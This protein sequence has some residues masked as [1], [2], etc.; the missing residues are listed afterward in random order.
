MYKHERKK[1]V[2]R[3]IPAGL[4][5]GMFVG[6]VANL[7]ASWRETLS[8]EV[9]LA[10]FAGWT[11]AGIVIAAIYAYLP[12][13]QEAWLL[14]QR[15][16]AKRREQLLKAISHYRP[17]HVGQHVHGVIR[18]MLERARVIEARVSA[19][20][21]D[22]LIIVSPGMSDEEAIA[23]WESRSKER[24]EK[25]QHSFAARK[26]E[27]EAATAHQRRQAEFDNAM[28]NAPKMER[29]EQAWQR[30][31][32]KTKSGYGSAVL[33]FAENWARLMQ[34]HIEEGQALDA[35]A[36]ETFHLADIEG[37]TGLMYG[38]AVSILASC[39]K[40]GEV[41]RRWHN[42]K[43]QI[44]TEGEEVNRSGGVLNPALLRIRFR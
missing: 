44:G 43:T 32:E 9:Q 39:W 37:I 42:L 19:V 41:L 14:E 7:I 21:N 8:N 4:W 23:I 31:V 15:E 16:N 38:A 33:R 22:Q 30:L 36:E 34:A 6:A 10:I 1:A 24:H 27:K 3:A 11:L 20:F 17:I 5:L 18:R 25:Y 13:K 2:I 40:Y 12:T 28:L 35:C 29:D 26:W